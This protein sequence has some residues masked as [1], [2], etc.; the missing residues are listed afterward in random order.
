MLMQKLLPMFL[1]KLCLKSKRILLVV[2]HRA[3][4]QCAIWVVVT[5]PCIVSL[6]LKEIRKIFLLL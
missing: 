4:D 2:M 3:E 5:K 1:K 6:I